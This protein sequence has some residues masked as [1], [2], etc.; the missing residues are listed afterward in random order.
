MSTQTMFICVSPNP[1]VDKRLEVASLVPGQVVRARSAQSFPGGKCAHVA[2][3]L[4]TLGEA[5]HWIGPCGG[6]T[7]A[8]L[9]DG[10]SALGIQTIGCPT[11]KPTR[12]NLEIIEDSGQVTEILEPG[13]AP[14]PAEL[15]AFEAACGKLFAEG[16][17]RAWAIFSGS[18][19][20]GVAPDLYGRLITRAR[21]CGCHTVLDTSGEALRMALPSAPDL[22]KPNREEAVHVLGGPMDL[23][24][25]AARA[26]RT[27]VS[28]GARRASISLGQ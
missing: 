23:L 27:M 11:A 26:A 25:D 10:L 5:A 4:R 3:V 6:R 24:S 20:S 2:M 1:A 14:S 16:G 13:S 12:T 28:L 18:L 19:P 8:E 22:V 17:K 9:L 21:T 7:G 15:A